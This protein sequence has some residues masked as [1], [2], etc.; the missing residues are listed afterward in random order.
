MEKR[1]DMMDFEES[2]REHTNRFTLTPSRRVWNSIYN[3]LHP[4]SKWPSKSISLMLLFSIIIVGN[5]NIGYRKSNPSLLISTQNNFSNKETLQNTS[6]HQQKKNNSHFITAYQAT[7]HAT[8]QGIPEP[9]LIPVDND[10]QPTPFDDL[11]SAVLT[12]KQSLNNSLKGYSTNSIPLKS[13]NPANK[14]YNSDINNQ[15]VVA[16]TSPEQLEILT[17]QIPILG[18]KMPD[19]DKLNAGELINP[20]TQIPSAV[21]M[22]KD[23]NENK[24]SQPSVAKI[25]LKKIRK[26]AWTFYLNP[27]ISSARFTAAPLS[28]SNISNTSPLMVSAPNITANRQYNARL[29][30]SVGAT[31]TLPIN[32]RFQFTSGLMLTYLGYQTTSNFIHPTFADLILKD[33]TGSTYLKSY[34]THYGNGLGYGQIQ[35]NNYSYQFAVP[36][37]LQYSIINNQKINWEIG[38][39]IAPSVVIAAQSYILSAEGR[40][41]LT[42]PGLGRRFNL[43]ANFESF[44]TFKSSGIKWQI[45][46]R[47]GYQVFSTFKNMNPEREHFFDYG[48][49]IGITGK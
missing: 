15:A 22:N 36:I 4:G 2:L 27:S 14:T 33:K 39:S 13:I 17:V 6:T 38:S 12:K 23:G 48:L 32:D 35:L 10:L 24:E 37:G 16:N 46:P 1:F 11:T 8:N 47:F 18:I 49:K 45:G 28:Q 19:M 41:Y 20:Q 34:I 9:L 25:S 40:N 44:V 31:S 5:V 7:S 43:L 30:L 3:D 21:A 26:G 42:D 29:S